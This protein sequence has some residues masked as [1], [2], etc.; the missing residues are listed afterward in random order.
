MELGVR[1]PADS[2]KET[3]PLTR[4]EVNAGIRKLLGS[5]KGLIRTAGITGGLGRRQRDDVAFLRMNTKGVQI[6][7]HP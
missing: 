2:L 7:N 1:G 6:G 5:G 3:S 4:F